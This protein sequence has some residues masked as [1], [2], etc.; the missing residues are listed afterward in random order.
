MSDWVC[1]ACTYINPA[2]G[3]ELSLACDVCATPKPLSPSSSDSDEDEEL[4]RALALSL[5]SA[6]D[7]P[8]VESDGLSDTDDEELYYTSEA[9]GEPPA[10]PADSSRGETSSLSAE[11]SA[12]PAHSS[13]LHATH[14]AVPVSAAAIPDR[15]ELERQR[16][17]RLTSKRK[18]FS[19]EYSLPPPAKRVLAYPMKYAGG[20]T[21]LTYVMGF[22]RVGS[23]RFED[24][25][26]QSYLQR[27]VCAAFQVDFEWLESKIPGH[28]KRAI[29]CPIF[30]D[31]PPGL[32]KLA[33]DEN[34]LCIFPPVNRGCMHVKFLL[35]FYPGFLRV[36]I[37][38]A[39]L[40]E[41]DWSAL[42]NVLWVQDFALHDEPPTSCPFGL[43]LENAL[44]EMGVP[45]SIVQAVRMADFGTA[46]AT[47]ILSKP[48]TFRGDEML[49]YG[50]PA[51]GECVKNFNIVGLAHDDATVIAQTSSLG[52]L[53]SGWLRN[54]H[55]SCL[56]LSI[57]ISE[58]APIP[59]IQIVYPTEKTIHASNLGP[60]GAGVITFSKETWEK[61]N[62]PRS[63][64]HNSISTRL[65]ALSH[66]KI[67]IA[68][69]PSEL[70]S[71]H[72]EIEEAGHKNA[73]GI[74]YL[75]S[76]NATQSA[77]G[78]LHKA[79]RPTSAQS[80]EPFP[81][82]SLR[83]ANWELGV[84]FPRTADGLSADVNAIPLVVPFTIPAP[85]YNRSDMPWTV[86][87][88]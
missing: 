66:C 16:L 57:D 88:R 78:A 55:R 17:A 30:S 71:G 14:E 51:L 4:R 5:Q 31:A 18:G 44:Q 38:S 41:H 34:T 50:H 26:E 65:G 75:G 80:R 36:V 25:V 86:S 20:H 7:V 83:I 11:R 60:D 6:N 61:S 29:V 3:R 45:E 49:R 46:R 74:Y 33:L 21:S 39:N 63:V 2:A 35:L 69:P 23:M 81:G 27:A 1:Q 22:N 70:Y 87:W 48:G 52:S 68:S 54:F 64:M 82:V 24:L 53:T 77:W 9:V 13:S 72:K 47:L 12:L 19:S 62:F 67:I 56:G 15:A 59:P 73:V 40:T 10:A 84:V 32:T 58:D 85:K 43:D 28:I 37:T 8:G 42:E 76:H 79:K